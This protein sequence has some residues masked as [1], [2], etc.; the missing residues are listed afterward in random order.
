MVL[1]ETAQPT[2]AQLTGTLASLRA[3]LDAR[4]LHD[5]LAVLVALVPDYTPSSTVL[6]FAR[7]CA[8]QVSL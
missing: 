5:A 4:D 6:E 1:I 8:R 3:A 2:T 7:Q